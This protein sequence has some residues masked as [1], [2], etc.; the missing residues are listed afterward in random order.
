MK[1]FLLSTLITILAFIAG[2]MV[3]LRF[4]YEE[5]PRLDLQKLENVAPEADPLHPGLALWRRLA[6]HAKW[7][8]RTGRWSVQGSDGFGSF[9]EISFGESYRIEGKWFFLPR[10]RVFFHHMMGSAAIDY[11]FS[12][13]PVMLHQSEDLFSNSWCRSGNH[14]EDL[15]VAFLRRDSVERAIVA[16]YTQLPQ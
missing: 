15:R 10:P 13:T 11:P 7:N 12:V 1:R 5:P 6:P 9:Y 2:A 8:E 3:T 14:E 16:A 4:T